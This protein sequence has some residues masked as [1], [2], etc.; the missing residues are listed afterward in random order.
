MHMMWTVP[1]NLPAAD[2]IHRLA[3]SHG[4]GLYPLAKAAAHEYGKAQLSGRSLV[5]GYTALS[6]IEIRDAI[7]RVATAIKDHMR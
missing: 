7:A 2:E 3:L 4:V 6:E 1:A 5:L